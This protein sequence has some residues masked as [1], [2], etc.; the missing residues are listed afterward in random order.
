MKFVLY[1]DIKKAC[2]DY[3]EEYCEYPESRF[4]GK[5]VLDFINDKISDGTI[6]IHEEE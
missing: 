1:E 2:E 4:E 3:D 6:K 5:S